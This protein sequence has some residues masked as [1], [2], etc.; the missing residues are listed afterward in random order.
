ML[1]E[2]QTAVVT[3]GSRGIGFQ[4]SKIFVEQGA[5]VLAISRSADKLSGAASALPGLET[6]VADT[7]DPGD[8]DR[9]VAWAA[10]NW[11]ALDILVN[12][13][14]IWTSAKADLTTPGDRDFIATNQTN[15]IGPY[16][17]TKRFLPLLL[18]SASPRVV[19][20]GSASGILSPRLQSAY[21]VSKAGLHALTI[22]T[23]Y[24][25]KGRVA[26]N[27]L[28]PGWVRTDMAPD[29]PNEPRMSA[30]AALELVT[31]PS[32]VTARLFQATS[33]DGNAPATAV[34]RAWVEF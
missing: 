33:S 4:I 27:V 13:A 15:L 6:L 9:A 11:G 26:V 19:N 12:N 14:G 1:L 34:E 7:S 8:I 31:M 22:A 17:S 5:R 28:S 20:I 16:L 24:E 23:A 18:E 32:Q 3:G 29:G 21:G 30:E 10:A 2:G 25:L